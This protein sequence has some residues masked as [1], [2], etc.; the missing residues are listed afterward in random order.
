MNIKTLLFVLA[1]YFGLCALNSFAQSSNWLWAKSAT[2]GPN[3]DYGNSI[4]TDANGNVYVTGDF[5]SSTITFGSITLTNTSSGGYTDVFIV[6]YDP[7]GNVM[8]AKRAGGPSAHD[9]GKSICVDANGDV[10]VTGYF[11]SPTITF[12]GTTLTNAGGSNIFIVKYDSSGNVIWAK[13]EGG[14]ANDEALSMCTDANGYMYLTGDFQSTTITFGGITLTNTGIVNVFVVKYDGSGNAVWAK[15]GAGITH[16]FGNT[17]STDALGNVYVG[18]VFYS[19]TI[20]FGSIALINTNANGISCDIFLVKYDNLGNVVWA[21]STGGTNT[22]DN[23]SSIKT[24]LNGNVYATGYFNS[25]TIAFGNIILTNA[26]AM[27]GGSTDLFIVK[28]DPS[29]NVLWAKKEGGTDAD[30]SNSIT[31][32]LN[33]NVYITGYFASPTITFGGTTLILTLNSW[34]IQELDLFIVKYDSSGNVICAMNAIG[35]Y[36]DFGNS[37]CTDANS[38]IHVTGGFDSPSI[39]FGSITLINAN[40]PGFASADIFTVKLTSCTVPPITIDVVSTN[41]NCNGQCNG[42]ATANPSGGIFPYTYLWSLSAGGQTTQ[43]ITGLCTGTYT[44][45]VTDAIGSDTTAT[46]TITQPTI[47]AANIVQPT[48]VTCNGLCNG[49]ATASASGGTPGYIFLWDPAAA[50]QTSATAS[51]LC[52][53]NYSVTVT[54]DNGC[55]TTQTVTITQP[56]V[57]VSGIAPPTDAT[58]DGFCNGSAT[59]SA[60][61]GTPGYTFVWNTVPIQTTASAIGLC[62]GNYSVTVTDANGCIGSNSNVTIIALYATPTASF[63]YQ[64]Q[65]TTI[66]NPVIQFTDSSVFNI[67]SWLWNFGDPE[68]ASSSLQNPN[69]TYTDTGE[70]IVK[71]IVT[72]IH[73]CMD[74][75]Q[76]PISI[77]ADYVFYAPNSFTPN[78]DGINDIFIPETEVIISTDYSFIIFD[79]WG[80]KVFETKEYKKGWD[81]KV[82]N[83]NTFAQEDVYVWTVKLSDFNHQQHDYMGRVTIVK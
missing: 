42:T 45:T 49:S 21:K 10:Y 25:D 14:T 44:V 78:N 20:T 76:H 40:S 58:C 29:G 16:D 23:I 56:N 18:G 4:A 11:V 71:L 82:K 24:D 65:P 75:V 7:F 77:T 68:N 48:N 28:Y 60:S 13:R 57:L 46:V 43:T 1:L 47:L 32:D 66:L 39:T 6:K 41:T 50:G 17:V 36:M 63:I 52:A 79:R 67:S 15:N 22:G 64:P 19:D 81:G 27:V 73:G 35:E 8:W 53:G 38:N 26:N 59:V 31:T 33:G 69:H 5:Y 37:I 74:T 55:T 9:S 12:G 34:S 30:Y 72:D 54:D 70:Y 51:N 61:G 80:N 3:Q 62:A 83:S 2:G